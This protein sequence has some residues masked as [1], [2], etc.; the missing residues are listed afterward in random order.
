MLSQEEISKCEH[1]HQ[2]MMERVEQQIASAKETRFRFL[3]PGKL[4]G[5]LKKSMD[6][7]LIMS[8]EQEVKSPRKL[9]VN[10]SATLQNPLSESTNYEMNST[11]SSDADNPILKKVQQVVTSRNQAPIN[12]GHMF[13]SL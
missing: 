13:R 6:R 10:Q 12:G 9:K 11:D 1:I 4:V 3:S 7:S 8:Y 2:E 5:K